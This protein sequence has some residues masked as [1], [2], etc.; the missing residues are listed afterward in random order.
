[1]KKKTKKSGK[2]KSE[3]NLKIVIFTADKFRII[4]NIIKKKERKDGRTNNFYMKNK[5]P[6]LQ[7]TKQTL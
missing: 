5:I 3:Q 1:M 4:S 7:N 6:S 2:K